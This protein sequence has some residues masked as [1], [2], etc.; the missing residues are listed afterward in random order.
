MAQPTTNTEF[1]AALKNLIDGWCERRSL[2][3]LARILSP[4]LGFS[5]MTDGWE[6]LAVAL[7]TVRAF[8]GEDISLREQGI[9]DDL[10]RATDKAVHVG[11]SAS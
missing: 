1:L 9:V 2:R 3:P 10:I 5:G 11:K 8:D 4:Y 7:K 6:E